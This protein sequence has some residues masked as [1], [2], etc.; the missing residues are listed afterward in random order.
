MKR[1]ISLPLP[2]ADDLFTTQEQRDD[3]K[4]ERVYEIE[5]ALIDEFPD[6]PFKVL[7]DESM[8]ELAVSIASSGVQTPV[9]VREKE[10]G[11]F[12]IIS[13][14]RRKRACEIAG[15]DTIPAIARNMS[16]D[17]AIIYM[18]E[19]NLQRERIL[20]SEKA[21]AYKMKLDAMNRQGTRT[22]LTSSPLGIKLRRKQSME[23]VGEDGGDSRSQVH[24][25]IRLTELIPKILNMVDEGAIKFRP[26]VELS[27][28]PAEKQEILCEIMESDECTPSHAQAIKMRHF[29]SEDKLT[30]EVILS[31]MAEEKP[32]QVEQFKMPKTRIE[33]FFSAGTKKKDVEDIIVKALEQYFSKEKNPRNM[34]RKR[35][36][37]DRGMER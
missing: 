35:E 4:L 22:D 36:A 24:R 8:A 25:Y 14:H 37:Q 19:S 18:V 27:Y 2:S 16:R 20:P 17:E 13:G 5:L 34:E 15:L 28:L 31:I 9:T 23:I 3:A 29:D 30:D 6:H 10:D 7:D 33:R 12:E 11:R 1:D 26:A 21:F 32:N